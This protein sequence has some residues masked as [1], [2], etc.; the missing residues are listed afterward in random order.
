M[1]KITSYRYFNKPRSTK[2]NDLSM[3]WSISLYHLVFSIVDYLRSVLGRIWIVRQVRFLALTRFMLV[4]RYAKSM[5][6]EYA[7]WPN[8][9]RSL[10]KPQHVSA[11]RKIGLKAALSKAKESR[12]LSS[13]S[14]F[15]FMTFFLGV[16]NILL[17]GIL[18][19]FRCRFCCTDGLATASASQFGTLR[20]VLWTKTCIRLFYVSSLSGLRHSDWL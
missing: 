16:P 1:T 20:E 7:L 18:W 9:E 12:P 13:R 5:Y 17:L 4:G 11:I 3:L 15:A 2:L 8:E 19:P 14:F 6:L 10:L